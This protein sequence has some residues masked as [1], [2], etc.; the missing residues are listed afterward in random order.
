M[1]IQEDQ[2]NKDATKKPMIQQTLFQSY[3]YARK[4]SRSLAE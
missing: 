4:K 2:P 1:D 3:T